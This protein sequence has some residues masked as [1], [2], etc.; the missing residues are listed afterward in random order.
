MNS[1]RFFRA[2][3]AAILAFGAVF[4]AMGQQSSWD[5]CRPRNPMTTL[6]SDDFSSS[7]VFNKNNG[8]FGLTIGV[9][10][11]TTYGSGDTTNPGFCFYPNGGSVTANARGRYGFW[12]YGQGTIQSPTDDGMALTFGM[13]ASPGGSWGYATIQ[14]G[15]PGQ[16]VTSSLFGR[17][18]F[19]LLFNGESDTYVYAQTVNGNVR[20]GARFDV[21]GDACRINWSL[22]NI[23]NGP[24][25]IG[26]QTGHI[27]SLLSATTNESRG[28]PGGGGESEV[29]DAV[30]GNGP[31]FV[32]VSGNRPPLVERRY[33]RAID[34]V[35]FPSSI[36][37][38]YSQSDAVG[39]RINNTKTDAT[40]DPADQSQS[41][42][43]VDEVALG[44]RVLLLGGFRGGDKDA[45]PDFTFGD[46]SDVGF[47]NVPA[48]IQKYYP[49]SVPNGGRRTIV[50]FI[51]SPWSDALYGR[52][53]SVVVDTPKVIN[54]AEN[55]ATT[56]Q[57]NPFTIRVN[58][59]NDRGFSTVERELPLE[60]VKITLNLPAGMRTVGPNIRTIS[61]IQPRAIAFTDFVVQV[62]P[63]VSGDQ[64]YSVTI[65]P[66][67]GPT[68]T[69]TGTLR[70]VSQPRLRIAAGANLISSPFIF[71]NPVWEDILGLQF[72]TDFQA[73]N[74][75]P[76]QQDYV[77][78]TGPIRGYGTWIVSRADRGVI[79]LQSNP[80]KPNDAL[81]DQGGAPL[82]SLK[83]GWNLI[84]N[85]YVRSSDRRT[86]ILRE[87]LPSP[88]LFSKGS[89]PDRS[90]STIRWRRRTASSKATP[91]DLSRNGVTGS[92]SPL[93]RT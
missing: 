84:G 54:L 36:S 14:Q 74:W 80:T 45:F 16:A 22:Q 31:V 2:S 93:S 58:V 40:T 17:N 18:G 43:D 72:D 79:T 61:R 10:G 3:G 55:D 26:L 25:N 78:S 6:H 20:I 38:L 13:P 39:M 62:D 4:P 15:A 69:V 64:T 12:I 5:I 81:P 35:N 71:Q 27:I 63:E 91:L 29:A 52:P 85:P 33:R 56:F 65:Q 53:Y 46:P 92:S 50:Q 32:D 37:F 11:T 90:R 59:D 68:K 67:P 34:P 66:S 48:Y 88:S 42:T 49:S 28:G 89:S 47:L 73:F 76:V 75:D 1:T 24:L 86:R 57:Q 51:N 60:D 77:I 19:E 87:R 70:V 41:L 8:M 7:A 23:S 83:Q 9:Q 82:I 21:I 44:S 30:A